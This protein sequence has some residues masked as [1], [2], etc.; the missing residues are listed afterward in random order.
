MSDKNMSAFPSIR[1][2][3]SYTQMIWGNAEFIGCAAAEY[4][5][6]IFSFEYDNKRK[7]VI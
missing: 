3:L 1:R 7:Y 6:F 2:S 4:F 5:L